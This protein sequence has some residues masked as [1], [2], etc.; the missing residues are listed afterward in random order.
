MKKIIAILISIAL[1]F[2]FAYADT[3]GIWHLTKDVRPGI[4]G[5]DEV[6]GDYTFI[7][8]LIVNFGKIFMNNQTSIYDRDEVVAT[9]GYVDE[10]GV[11]AGAVMSFAMNDC[12]KGWLK[13]DG[14]TVSRT[15]YPRLFSNIGTFYGSGDG[16]TTFGLP[17]LRGYFIRAYDDG[18]NRDIGRVFA[19]LQTDSFASHRHTVNPD[20]TQSTSTG[21]HNHGASTQSGGTHTHTGST[22]D[23]GNHRHSFDGN[24][25]EQHVVGETS[26]SVPVIFAASKNTNYAGTHSHSLTIN[27]A[28]SSHTHAISSSGPHA[29]FVDIPEFNSG[30]T[31]G[32]ETRP[33]NIALLYC[34]KY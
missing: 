24:V 13:A 8:N 2:G 4:F 28:G 33:V 5:S 17:D 30:F 29:H 3:N 32:G 9:K 19:S 7:D 11:P 34:I 27:A 12:P 10:Y 20:N 15:T 22:N 1:L 23:A 26:Y 18:A 16:S 25:I 31:G 6:R 21:D 14:Q